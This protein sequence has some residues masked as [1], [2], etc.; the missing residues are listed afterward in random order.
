MVRPVLRSTLFALQGERVARLNGHAA[1]TLTDLAREYREGDGDCGICFEYAVH[2]AIERADPLIQPRISEVLEKFCRLRGE[3]RSVLFGAEKGK[4][5]ELL[6]T[7]PGLFTPES[8]LLVGT[9]NRP[10][11][12]ERHLARV[13]RAFNQPEERTALP[14][15]IR[16]LW[17]ADLF[18][19]TPAHDR[20]VA[21]TLKTHSR[22]LEG[23]AGI[24]IGIYPEETAGES[25]SLDA[26]RNLVLCPV[27]YE[28]GFMELFYQCFVLVKK[29]LGADARVPKPVDLP[30][31]PDRQVARWLEERREFPVL[32]VIASF[33][34]LAQP[35]L[36]VSSSVGDPY[37]VGTTTSAIAPV[38]RTTTR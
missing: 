32:D 37:A 36:L 11:K 31:S 18:V 3:T 8:T 22:D 23:A 27:P 21:T 35:N 15:S 6:E 10:I 33:E 9:A 25:P 28:R 5:L 4:K 34:S 12:L 24:R 1:I 29:F 17:R 2:D 13:R 16:G 26:G 20:W 14:R 38:A 19:G 7:A 30:G